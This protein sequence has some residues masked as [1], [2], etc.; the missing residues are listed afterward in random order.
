MISVK[1]LFESGAGVKTSDN[2]H[3]KVNGPVLEVNTE[4]HG[5]FLQSE[6]HEV[7]IASLLVYGTDIGF[8]VRVVYEHF[9]SLPHVIGRTSSTRSNQSAT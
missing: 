4:S 7:G 3:G 6:A 1:E 9:L 2:V 5:V 8:R